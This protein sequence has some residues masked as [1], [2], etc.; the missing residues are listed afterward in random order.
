MIVK[1]LVIIIGLHI[2][3]LHLLYAQIINSSDTLY[4]NEW[5]NYTQTY[6]RLNISSDGI[7]RIPASE[8]SAAGIPLSMVAGR[9]FRMYRMGQ[10]VPLFTSTDTTLT[11]SDFIEFYATKHKSD[12]D[13]YMFR[14]NSGL[15]LNPDYSFINDTMGYFLTWVTDATNG[16][17]ITTQTNDLNNAPIKEAWFWFKDRRTFNQQD[18]HHRFGDIFI[19]DFSKGEGYGSA[20][21]K[22]FKLA[23]T[24]VSRVNTEGG[25]LHIRWANQQFH[26]GVLS[27]NSVQL[28]R[29]TI[30]SFNLTEKN[31]S[32]TAAQMKPTMDITLSGVYSTT[33]RVSVGVV[34]LRYARQF[35]FGNA[36]YFEFEIQ[37]SDAAKYLEID[38]FN[39][40]GVAPIL[41]DLTN[42]TRMTTTLQAGKV[43]VVIPPSAQA[44]RFVLVNV[45][46]AIRTVNSLSKVVFKD[47]KNDDAE[48]IIITS[49]KYINDGIANE[50]AQYRQSLAGGSYKTT[51]I[52]IKDLYEQFGYGINRHPMAIRDFSHFIKKNW[53]NPKFILL[54][55]KGREFN[56]IRSAA[57]LSAQLATYDIPTW[58]YP[59]SDILM[60]ATNTSDKP[61]IPVGRL[62][63][64][65]ATDVRIYLNKVKEWES[66]QKNAP[67][68]VHDRD[69]FKNML[70]LSGGGS[71]GVPIKHQLKVFESTLANGKFGATVST[72]Y[73][74]SVDPV[75]VAQNDKIFD[76][77]NKGVSLI[78]FFGHSATSVLE[79]DVNNPNLLTNKSKTPL[80]IALGCSAGNVH[81]ASIGVSENF[82]FYP[83]KGM[84]AFIGTSGTSYLSSLSNFGTNFYDFIANAGFDEKIGT[85]VQ[86]SI[87]KTGTNVPLDVRSI[88]QS[89]TIHGDPAT[90]I[91]TA[92]GADFVIDAATV[93]INPALITA[94]TDSINVQFDVVNIGTTI[95]DTIRLIF[96]Q[97][98]PD[99]SLFDL[100]SIKIST[101]Q[102][103]STLDV[104]L[105]L[106]Q[107]SAVGNNRLHITLDADNKVFELPAP[108]GEFN[109]DLVDPTGRKG[110]EFLVLA[111]NVLPAYPPPLS[112]IGK[113]PVVLKASTSNP[114]AQAQNY[115]FEID[116]TQ[117]FNSPLKQQTLINAKGGVLKW[118]PTLTWKDSTVYYWRTAVESP[119]GTHNWQNS[120]FTY[121]TGK[122]GW[123]QGH[124]FQFLGN[125]LKDIV[126]NEGSR[127]MEYVEDDLPVEIRVNNVDLRFYP[128][129]FINN[130]YLSANPASDNAFPE[131]CFLITVFDFD[132]T[133]GDGNIWPSV[134]ASGGRRNYG[135][136]NRQIFNRTSFVFDSN[137]SDASIGRQ[138]A[139]NFINNIVS[140]NAYVL[141]YVTTKNRSSRHKANTW[142]Q[143]SIFF[144]RNIFQVIEGQGAN[145]FREL[146]SKDSV[147][148]F[149]V[150]KK[151][152]HH[153]LKE[154]VQNSYINGTNETF[155]IP[156]KWYTGTQTTQLVGVAKQWHQ[157]ELS[158]TT[159]LGDTLGV[160]IIG[161]AADA[162]T[163]TVLK[164]D[165]TGSIS[166]SDID[167]AKYPYLKLK[168][169]S[170]DIRQQTPPQLQ[171][172]RIYYQGVPDL[173]VNP[174]IQ[175]SQSKDTL[176][177]GETFALQVGIEN[178]SDYDADSVAVALSLRNEQ[179]QS[180]VLQKKLKPLA[181][182]EN[183]VAPFDYT[184]Q[185]LSGTQQVSLEVNPKQTQPE[186]FTANNFLQ[187][188]LVVQKDNTNP[189]LDVTFDGMRILNNDIV[190]SRPKIVVQLRDNNPFLPL[191]D[192][193]LF[194]ITIEPVSPAGT[195][196]TLSFSDPSV[197]FT[198][199]ALAKNDNKATIEFNPDFLKDG[200]YRLVVR[201]R[202]ASGNHSGINDYSV[203]FRVISRQ[204]ISQVLPYPNPFST[205]TRFAYTLTGD[206]PPQYI[207]IQIMTVSGKVVHEITQNE[208][209]AL[210]IGTHL[211][212][213]A[214]D[215][216]DEYGSPLANGV[217]LYRVIAKDK[218]KQKIE[219]YEN[220]DND[221]DVYFK[222]DFGKIVIMR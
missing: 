122:N 165:I 32:L 188:R 63:A 24:P 92:P 167:A 133:Q 174:T 2:S 218:N 147:H 128:S 61:I 114:L 66:V 191:N 142:G 106:V 81:Q 222:K 44:R 94:Q 172:W 91:A 56:A 87:E 34:E 183:L 65:S 210:R 77:I 117:L 107:K 120:S 71:V 151:N 59:G 148:Y 131:S 170:R 115:L 47:I 198:P 153:I 161:L 104:R 143:D 141:F 9:Q 62:A 152:G 176:Q 216:K 112:I 121:I 187:S 159:G 14:D 86:K 67:Q 76:R 145:H 211:T 197:R 207:T 168:Y 163:E 90:K 175:Y 154:K 164:K 137:S 15:N 109:N 75:E 13:K 132:K 220:L 108:A 182:G 64:S 150:F 190:S 205:S 135:M 96:K 215:G 193:A 36:T 192:T 55:G 20:W 206:T 146:I 209:G 169:Q 139:I 158:Y 113:S 156:R 6:L 70:H 10:E 7:Y 119:T 185:S 12:L 217:Y 74:N 35:N 180:V 212:D 195:V 52:N 101:P 68:T 93:K 40:G 98:L 5:I 213:Y 41:Y 53:S 196:H 99:G 177:Q 138:G 45:N 31:I 33:D 136:E 57:Q 29:D 58:G 155:S 186:T 50:Y 179:N 127:E 8:L 124:Y 219:Q 204:S 60:V 22:D 46:S 11:S 21:A 157:L 103:R 105:P 208:L 4:G 17:R 23:V 30:G 69:F 26:Y 199:A 221:L 1:R 3:F 125:T 80:F 100:T 203:H 200:S 160:D 48:Y 25:H 123:A 27:L 202:D 189:L 110:Y 140:D 129:Y 84:S 102:Y 19:S 42:N 116:T 82:I 111:N 79:F 214:W 126:M 54:I 89:F 130:Q 78:T 43:Q 18:I 134:Q 49:D 173:A 72:F 171:S 73:K 88:L 194:K 39:T 38:N 178:L 95:K 144:G 184:T 181:A 51:I 118:Q 83:D 166:L 201:A 85:I 16:K 149:V 97:Q 162:K 28:T 37:E